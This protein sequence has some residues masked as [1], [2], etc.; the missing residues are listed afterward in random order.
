MD[1]QCSSGRKK[2][3]LRLCIDPKEL[4]TAIK[5]P[6]YQIPTVDEILPK[7]AKAFTVLDAKDGFFQIKLDEESS[8]LTTF[9]TLFARYRYERCP[10]G[11]SSAP[12]EYQRRQKEILEG[13]DV[14]ADDNICYGSG[15]TKEDAIH[16]SHLGINACIRRAKDVIYW[17][18]MAGEITD[19]VKMCSTC[20]EFMDKQQKEPLMTH[21]I[22]HLPWS[23]VGQDLFSLYG[24]DYLVTVDYFSD[25]F[26]ID[27][28]DDTSAESVINATKDHF[29]RHGIADMVTDNGPQYTSQKFEDFKTMGFQAHHQFT[30]PQS[31][32]MRRQNQLSKLPRN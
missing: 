13:L 4:N 16:K 5:R 28:L 19:A 21:K 29:A 24:N 22:P 14:I 20:C 15:E 26:E 17:P 10:F 6:K 30:V 1:L 23:K 7:L 11:I 18:G 8:Y 32:V 12:E 2:G 3:K 25:Y 27:T 9:W 31:R